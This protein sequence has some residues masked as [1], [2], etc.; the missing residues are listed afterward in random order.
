MAKQK[1]VPTHEA[2]VLV[3]HIRVEPVQ[4]YFRPYRGGTVFTVINSD[5]ENRA[6]YWAKGSRWEGSSVV[7]SLGTTRTLDLDSVIPLEGPER[8]KVLAALEV[9]RKAKEEEEKAD[10]IRRKPFVDRAEAFEAKMRAFL[11]QSTRFTPGS[12][13]VTRRGLAV[14]VGD[15]QN[16]IVFRLRD[17]DIYSSQSDHVTIQGRGFDLQGLLVMHRLTRA[18]EA[19]V[20]IERGLEIFKALDVPPSSKS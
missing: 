18:V 6:S 8:E 5:G 20:I 7:S 1:P 15:P 11:D 4:G 3:D 12:W 9:A 19:Q 14:Q 13:A 17:P 2:K 10:R 16:F